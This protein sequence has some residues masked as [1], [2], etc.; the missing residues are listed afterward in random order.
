VTTP[1]PAAAQPAL[2][3]TRL[4]DQLERS[5]R[6]GAWHGPSL[7]QAVEGVDAATATARPIPGA[8][9][10]HELVWH[11]AFWLDVGRQRIVGAPPAPL[12]AEGDWPPA[13]LD[14]GEAWRDAVERLEHSYRALLATVLDLSDSKLEDPV[15]GSDPTV[16]GLLLGLLQHNSYH[17]GQ[18][19][20]LRRAAEGSGR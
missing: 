5:L 8:H 10:I 7:L 1:T 18:I 19:V 4:A 15:S 20:L 3:P 13:D 14:P 16:R 2:E 11:A 12:A 6:G 17:A 9:T